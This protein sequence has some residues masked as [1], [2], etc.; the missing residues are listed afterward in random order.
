MTNFHEEPTYTVGITFEDKSTVSL[1]DVTLEGIDE[2]R[3]YFYGFYF[4]DKTSQFFSVNK[5]FSLAYGKDKAAYI[6]YWRSRE[7][8]EKLGEC[9]C[10]TEAG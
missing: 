6:D 2:G 10:C 8:V 1:K 3:P 4:K 5:I 7:Q 9:G